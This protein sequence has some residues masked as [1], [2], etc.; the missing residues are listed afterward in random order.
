M[1]V[2]DAVAAG[3]ALIS[4]FWRTRLAVFHLEPAWRERKVFSLH[5]D[6]HTEKRRSLEPD[7]ERYRNNRGASLERERLHTSFVW[8]GEEARVTEKSDV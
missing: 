7:P 5:D 4:Q 6:A 3:Q 8:R 2:R 1:T